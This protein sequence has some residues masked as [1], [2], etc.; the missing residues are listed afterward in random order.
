VFKS[1]NKRDVV[2]WSSLLLGYVK[3]GQ[4]K[5]VLGL[6][7]QMQNELVEPN[8]FTFV[9]VLKAC[10]SLEALD[11]GRD[12]HAQII[13]LGFETDIFVGSGL[14]DMYSK[15][16][17]MDDGWRVFSNMPKRN[18][19]TWNAIILGYLKYGQGERALELCEQMV[20]ESLDPSPATFVG[21]LNACAKLESLADGKRVHDL[22]IQSGCEL[23]PFVVSSLVNMYAKCGSLE[24]AWEMFKTLSKPD[25]VAWDAMILG[26]LKC[27][28]QHKALDLLRQMQHEGIEPDRH[29]F[30]RVSKE[31]IELAAVTEASCIHEEIS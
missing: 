6:F 1:L 13:H 24:Y 16:G 23:N 28:Q 20:Q 15:C 3:F 7:K 2:A 27:G 5:K 30:V 14:I 10:S 9:A 21:M 18:Q 22:I 12:V 26:Y 4:A 17:C 8:Q 19:V 11:E 29:M 25:V 31:G